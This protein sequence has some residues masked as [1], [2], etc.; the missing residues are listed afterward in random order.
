MTRAQRQAQIPAPTY[1]TVRDVALKAIADAP[2]VETA[3]RALGEASL[4]T[5]NRKTLR[6]LRAAVEAKRNPQSTAQVL[7]QKLVDQCAGMIQRRKLLQ[8]AFPKP[9]AKL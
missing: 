6:I 9:E 4:M 1:T 8:P 2:D 3:E 5:S 7:S